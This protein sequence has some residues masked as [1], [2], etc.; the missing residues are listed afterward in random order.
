MAERRMLVLGASGTR[1]GRRCAGRSRAPASSPAGLLP[2]RASLEMRAAW[3]V[4]AARLAQPRGCWAAQVWDEKTSAR[5]V[6][7]VR[8]QDARCWE[9]MP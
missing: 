9:R 8:T 7:E 4:S 6:N 3:A 5:M 2:C 1:L